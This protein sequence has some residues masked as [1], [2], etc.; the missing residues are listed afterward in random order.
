[1]FGYNLRRR[2]NNTTGYDKPAHPIPQGLEPSPSTMMN[3]TKPVGGLN[4]EI[5]CMGVSVCSFLLRTP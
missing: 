4:L 5:V 2:A 1:M 3:Q